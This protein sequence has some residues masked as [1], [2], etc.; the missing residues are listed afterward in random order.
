MLP[1]LTSAFLIGLFLGSRF[2]FFPLSIMAVLAAVA[3]FL[4]ILER[5]A[6]IGGGVAHC[7]YG[8]VL[9]GMCYWSLFSLM[10]GHERFSTMPDT[11]GRELV[12]RVVA[13]VQHAPNRV[14][15]TVQCDHMQPCE[16]ARIRLVWRAP[17]L[18]VF[19]GDRVAFRTG[20]RPPSG[21]L[22]PG[23]F[24]YAAYLERQGIAAVG[25]A[26][27]PRAVR[28]LESGRDRAQWA[29]WN[30][31][32]RWRAD[33][34]EAAQQTLTQPA[35]GLYLGIII[36]DRGY[37]DEDL[38]DQFMV[39]GT[40]H[41]LSISGSHLGLIAL[42]SFLLLK[43]LALML[44]ASW[45]VNV[46]RAVTP[47]RLAAALTVPPVLLYALL[48]GAE[49]ATIRSLIM[50]LV[51]LLALW[52]G[53]ERELLH[54]LAAAALMLVLHDPRAM[55]DISFQLSFVSVLAIALLLWRRGCDSTPSAMMER[56]VRWCKEA[57]RLSGVVTLATLPLVALYFNQI[58]WMGVVTNLAA[59][60]FT[61][62]IL[63]PVGLASALW[64]VAMGGT[65]LVLAS[66][67][68]ILCDGMVAAVRMLSLVPGSEWHV[69]A[70]SVPIIIL[71]YVACF[72]GFWSTSPNADRAAAWAALGVMLL[73]WIW[74]PRLVDGDRFRVTFLD[75]GQGD[76][77][78]VEL[79]DGQV[80]LIDG[81]GT[82][83]RFDMGRGVVGP[84]LWNRGIRSLDHVVGTHPQL[85]HVGGLAW[86]VRHFPVR[87][88]WTTGERREER[89]FER[90]EQALHERRVDRQ[91]ATEG[92]ELLMPGPCRLS[93]LHPSAP[94]VPS[95]GQV[96]RTSGAD[97]NNRSLVTRLDCGVQ[98]VLFT[99]DAETA[100][101]RRL[102]EASSSGPVTVLK[103]PHHGA[104]GS[105]DPE[106]LRR[107]A[108]RYAV[109]S[110]GRR[111]PYGHPAPA[112]LEAYAAERV[113]V[114]RTDIDGAVWITGRLSSD[115][116][117][118]GR[119]RDLQFERTDPSACLLRCEWANWTRVWAQ[120]S[121]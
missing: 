102:M 108:P 99:G 90:L 119:W 8:A 82:Y 44:P 7:L 62:F 48:A 89:F 50:I 117:S 19:H 96:M 45:L 13:P 22:N 52:L 26:T 91:I 106:W 1:S 105:L 59:V 25:T 75:V 63:V 101:L 55:L 40:V 28:V 88:Y 118:V 92:T 29:L 5:R 53:H 57:I 116:L 120:W 87:R 103:I 16:A 6:R 32:D 37:L 68:Q 111:N 71:Y 42:L 67:T 70:P 112:V 98:S 113:P 74:S 86:V 17:D 23:G 93:A 107:M 83:E 46:F 20:L 60:P 65:E 10:N 21:P 84:F 94:D 104:K 30:R 109:V 43:R 38:R 58:P 35:L 47:T 72:R 34:R 79:P 66:V 12:G 100:A 56:I 2:P 95:G 27:G 115:T 76:S 54:A 14:T 121:R 81:G 49:V 4:A 78:V 97:L 3:V 114:L 33:I 64:H 11:D 9:A 69:A 85:D 51:A 110:A 61:G 15:L 24:D 77:A 39:T 18:P 41:L 73:W 36:G 31:I 80:V